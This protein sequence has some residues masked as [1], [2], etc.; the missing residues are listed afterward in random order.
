[1]SYPTSVTMLLSLREVKKY[2]E[3]WCLIQS[4]FDAVASI[5]C[6]TTSH[7]SGKETPGSYSSYAYLLM[8]TL[9]HHIPKGY[10]KSISLFLHQWP[11]IRTKPWA[12]I[13]SKWYGPYHQLLE[14]SF[15][16]LSIISKLMLYV[17]IKL[18]QGIDLIFWLQLTTHFVHYI[19]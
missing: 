11:F 19:M 1:M 6:C 17:I 16:C 18:N 8:K 10:S 5:W 7:D 14:F 4:L 15:T 3:T 2:I 13:L 12:H 9:L